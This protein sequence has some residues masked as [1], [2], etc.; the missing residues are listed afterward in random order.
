M[1]GEETKRGIGGT[2]K[3]SEILKVAMTLILK[4]CMFKDSD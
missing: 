3:S 4:H 2:H 1:R